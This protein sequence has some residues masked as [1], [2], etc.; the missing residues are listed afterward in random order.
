MM[1]VLFLIAYFSMLG[2][3]IYIESSDTINM[4]QGENSMM[5]ELQILFGAI[6]A[7]LGQVINYWFGSGDKK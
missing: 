7:G 1:S 6:T 5:N 2:A 4:K 3:I